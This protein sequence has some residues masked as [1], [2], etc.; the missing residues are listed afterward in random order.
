LESLNTFLR[1]KL[2]SMTSLAVLGVGSQLRADDAAGMMLVEKLSQAFPKGKCS[3]LLLCPGETAP[4]NYSGKIRT[5]APSH[6]L[7]VDAA[8]LSKEPGAFVDIDPR[9]VGGP[10]Y[11]SHMLPI[12]VMVDYVVDGMDT[13]VTLLG[14]QYKSIAFDG[15]MSGE[16][17]S[18]VDDVFES[19]RDLITEKLKKD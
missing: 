14:I 19:L 6:L 5:F 3:S 13:N 4:E 11:C 12:K 15:E 8:D 18:T 17:Q 7:I 9:D 1:D 16:V 10:T 2:E